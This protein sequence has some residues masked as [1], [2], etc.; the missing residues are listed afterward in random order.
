VDGVIVVA[1]A[2][3]TN[4]RAVASVLAILNRLRAKVVGLVL[5]EVHKELSDSYYYYDYYR[6][7]H[8]GHE[9]REEVSS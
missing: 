9:I 3:R 5:N 1:R 4:R 6:S 2:G 7:Y 8:R